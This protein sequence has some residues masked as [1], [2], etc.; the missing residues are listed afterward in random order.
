[1]QAIVGSCPKSHRSAKSGMRF[2]KWFAG[3]VLGWRGDVL[4]PTLDGLLQWSRLFRCHK[5]FGNYVAY[6]KLAC[7]IVSAPVDVFSHPSVRRAKMAI[8]KRRLLAPR[9][10]TWVRL[11]VLQRIMAAVDG[12]PELRQLSMVF[13]AAYVFLLRLPS[14][15]LPMA[16]HAAPANVETPVLSMVGEA[17]IKLQFP[18]RKN[19]LWPTQQTRSCWC[20]QC[21]LTCPVHVLGAY[22]KDLPAGSQPFV[23]IR[24]AQALLALR[25]LLA[26]LHIPDAELYRT[27]DFRRGHA[28]DLRMWGKTLREILEAGD[29]SSAAFAAYLDKERLERDRVE[30]AHVADLFES[31]DEKLLDE[32]DSSAG[33]VNK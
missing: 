11:A 13:L 15:G 20:H 22:I 2:W 31:D 30:E 12:R 28:E 9:K 6:V 4:P 23:H 3:N 26:A 16:A 7:E 14:E 5:T 10:P 18:F 8:E 21:K 24:P 17:E 33:P 1:M 29:W 32:A 25:E 27:Q 19:R